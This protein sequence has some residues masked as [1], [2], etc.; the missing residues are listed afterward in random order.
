M[1]PDYELGALVAAFVQLVAH[2]E[3]KGALD[4]DEF[5][6]CLEAGSDALSVDETGAALKRLAAAVRKPTPRLVP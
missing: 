4:R 2:L 6:A 3:T 5:A 1:E